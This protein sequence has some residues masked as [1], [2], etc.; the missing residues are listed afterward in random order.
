VLSAPVIQQVTR[1]EDYGAFVEF[2]Y[3]GKKLS[4]LLQ[5]EEAKVRASPA[6]GRHGL[7]LQHSSAQMVVL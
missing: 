1:L 3:E 4:A 5:S 7:L 2:E 6:A